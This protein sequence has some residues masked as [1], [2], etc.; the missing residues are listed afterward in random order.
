MRALLGYSCSDSALIQ[1][2]SLLLVFQLQQCLFKASSWVESPPHALQEVLA[3]EML[4][5]DEP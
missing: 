3:G 2:P 5:Q 1:S 4:A